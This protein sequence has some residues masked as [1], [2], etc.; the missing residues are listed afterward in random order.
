M[1]RNAEDTSKEMAK[2][3]LVLAAGTVLGIGISAV[4]FPHGV[5]PPAAISMQAL[6]PDFSTVITRIPVLAVKS[7]DNTGIVT[8]ASVEI[9]PGKGRVLINTNPFVEP[10]TQYSAETA[11]KIAQ[12][13]TKKSINQ[14]DVILTF[15]AETQ[16]VG[17]PSAGA[18]MTIAAIAAIQNK[19][20]PADVAMTGTVEEDGSVGQVGGVLEKAEAAAEAGIRLFLVPRGE[21]RLRYYEAQTVQRRMGAF[22]VQETRYVPKTLDLV[23]YMEEKYGMEVREVAD[24]REAA[25]AFGL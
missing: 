2:F 14:K 10:D 23:A 24:I 5:E 12:E 7:S 17:G 1:R 21:A 9:R 6:P 19:T 8:F 25:G 20:L 13:Y 18:A 16:L 11:V 15:E 3:V 22:V 4:A